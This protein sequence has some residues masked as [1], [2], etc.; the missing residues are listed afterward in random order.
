MAAMKQ[1]AGLTSILVLWMSL[2][3]FLRVGAQQTGESG[4][5][6]KLEGVIS[7]SMCGARHM[8]SG[9]DAKCTRTCV[10]G[11]SLY[12]LLVG[13]EVHELIGRNEDLDRLAGERVEIS[14]AISTGGAIRV[15]SVRPSPK[16]PS[17]GATG[18]AKSP[19]ANSET[20]RTE[21]IE[22]LVR[23]ISCPVQNKMAAAR[24]F[25]LKCAL[26]CVRLGS[27]M[28]IQTDDGTLYAPISSAMPDQDQRPR[29]MPFVGKYVEVRGQVFE[30]QGTR[31]IMVEDVKELKGVKLETNAQ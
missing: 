12:V 6:V 11:G 10:S 29:L 18:L 22:G 28:I 9:D 30:R 27:P 17:L 26:E 24:V 19:Q 31:A 5:P 15:A 2:S 14:G 13:N 16:S 3:G 7:D 8:M 21:T 23:D 20:H 4:Q 1:I 25:N